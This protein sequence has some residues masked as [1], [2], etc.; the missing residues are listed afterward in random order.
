MSKSIDLTGK[1][2]GKLIVL[3]SAGKNAFGSSLWRCIC[4][5]KDGKYITTTTNKLTSGHTKFCGCLRSEV[6]TKRNRRRK[7]EFISRLR[8]IW[9]NMRDRCHNH[10]NAQYKDYGGRGITVCEE[11]RY[12][13]DGFENFKKWAIENGYENDLTIERIDVNGNYEPDNCTWIDKNKQARNRRDTVRLKD[14]TPLVTYCEDNDL[15]YNTCRKR[16]KDLGWT[17]DQAVGLEPRDGYDHSVTTRHGLRYHPLYFTWR[18]MLNRAKRDEHDVCEDW[19]DSFDGIRKFISWSEVNGWLEGCG[20]MLLR[21]DINEGYS[22]DNCIWG[23]DYDRKINTS[24]TIRL[25]DGTSVADHCK[26]HGLNYGAISGRIQRG[27]SSDKAISTPVE[28]S[29]TQTYL[30][31]GVRYTIPEYCKK[32][33]LNYSTVKSRMNVGGKSF[34]EAVGIDVNSHRL[35]APDGTYLSDYCKEHGLNYNTIK[36]RVNIGGMSVEEA[37][38]LSTFKP[39]CVLKNGDSLSYF[40][41][42]YGINLGSIKKIMEKEDKSADEVISRYIENNIKKF[43][44]MS[45]DDILKLCP[46]NGRIILNLIDNYKKERCS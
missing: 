37:I 21:I 34:E 45:T 28:I 14:G 5:C 36:T 46:D 32:F 15:N 6:T 18:N 13:E 16:V 17:P 29:T 24:R 44:N 25:S 33:N 42:K 39:K 27:I 12:L 22:P 20:K 40:C 10:N 41:R 26:K 7:S 30:I 31:D 4:S 8:N 38:K 11:W 3:N 1:T 23:T 19:N 9:S 35:V 2:F 43:I